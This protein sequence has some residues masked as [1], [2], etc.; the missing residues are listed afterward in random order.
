MEQEE[1][2]CHASTNDYLACFSKCKWNTISILCY[3]IGSKIRV[4]Y[5][6][7]SLCLCSALLYFKHF[8]S[9]FWNDSFLMRMYRFSSAVNVFNYSFNFRALLMVEGWSTALDKQLI[10]R[11]F[12]RRYFFIRALL[13]FSQC[14][15]CLPFCKSLDAQST[16]YVSAVKQDSSQKYVYISVIWNRCPNSLWCQV[17]TVK[18]EEYKWKSYHHFFQRSSCLRWNYIHCIIL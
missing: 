15:N 11:L 16:V 18:V 9:W 17:D 12:N 4:T 6:Q 13:M 3:C 2:T 1:N 8:I 5:R 7:D 14:V 10:I